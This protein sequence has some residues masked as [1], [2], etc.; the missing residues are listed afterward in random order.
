VPPEEEL[1]G[2]GVAYAAGIAVGIYKLDEVFSSVNRRAFVPQMSEG[3]RNQKYAGWKE[4]VD[5]VLR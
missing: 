5:K 3:I 4:A 2:I 1:S